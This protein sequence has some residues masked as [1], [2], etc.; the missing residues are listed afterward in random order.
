M[1]VRTDGELD[2]EGL[3]FCLGE[4]NV[5]IIVAKTKMDK[6]DEME[7]LEAARLCLG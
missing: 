5:A 4:S 2:S 6:L 7:Q 3:A 1:L